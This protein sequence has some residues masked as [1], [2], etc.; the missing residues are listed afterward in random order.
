MIERVVMIRLDAAFRDQLPEVVAATREVLAPIPGVRAL[1]VGVP[2]DDRTT[3]DWDVCIEVRFDDLA[4]VEVYRAHQRHRNYVE[5]FLRPMLE[6][7]RVWNFE[8]GPD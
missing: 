7:I 2:A 3:R 5:V 4:A 8:V 1:R 6:R